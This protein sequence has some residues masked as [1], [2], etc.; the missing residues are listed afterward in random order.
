MKRRIILLGPPASG[1]G[2]QAEMIAERYG[3]KSVSTGAL[4]RRE[5]EE[6]T[7][8]GREAEIWTRRGLL[9]PDSIAL[10]V[11]D[12]WLRE[13]GA[14]AYLFDGF[15]RTIGQAQAFDRKAGANRPEIV[16][17]LSL[18]DDVIRARVADR[19]TC[20]FCGATY[21]GEIHHVSAGDAC[22]DC[23]HTL[24]RRNDD[25]PEALTERLE[26]HRELTE[27]LMAYYRTDGRLEEIDASAD[28]Q[29]I[30]QRIC[31]HIEE[32]VTA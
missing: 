3:L 1:K 7:E 4:L 25:T 32:A 13:A 31:D 15:P 22:P 10:R 19:I 17:H 26:Q 8:L 28:R 23:G 9:F 12:R 27:P 20:T 16:F 14:E 21:S 6:G 29:V 2:T 11:V 30:F 24:E 5:R 18:P